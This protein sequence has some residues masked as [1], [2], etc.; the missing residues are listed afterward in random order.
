MENFTLER[1]WERRQQQC[2]FSP[3]LLLLSTAAFKKLEKHVCLGIR[4]ISR[5]WKESRCARLHAAAGS[6]SPARRRLHSLCRRA[7]PWE[8]RHCRR[9]RRSFC[10]RNSSKPTRMH[11]FWWASAAERPLPSLFF[12]WERPEAAHLTAGS[13]KPAASTGRGNK[14]ANRKR[15]WAF[16]AW[17]WFTLSCPPWFQPKQTGGNSGFELPLRIQHIDLMDSHGRDAPVRPSA[18][19]VSGAIE[20]LNVRQRHRGE[21]KSSFHSNAFCN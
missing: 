5:A 1:W 4:G 13:L 2:F 15:E 19:S 7:S 3:P 18:A 21:K 10:L 16:A 12:L 9:R 8:R 14:R 20:A 11:L 17:K 6:L